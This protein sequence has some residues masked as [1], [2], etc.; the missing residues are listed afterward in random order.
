LG[1][2]ACPVLVE[3]RCLS[4][5]READRSRLEEQ[6]HLAVCAVSPNC[7]LGGHVF[8]GRSGCPQPQTHPSDFR[9]VSALCRG[10]SGAC[11]PIER[12]VRCEQDTNGHTSALA[13]LV[14]HTRGFRPLLCRSH[15][16]STAAT[17]VAAVLEFAPSWAI[18]ASSAARLC[19]LESPRACVGSFRPDAQ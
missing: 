14:K 1:A 19:R 9:R 17:V 11:R 5:F 10:P 13:T 18:A 3:R 7:S 6:R 8:R 4:R 16:K 12:V 15:R 2:F